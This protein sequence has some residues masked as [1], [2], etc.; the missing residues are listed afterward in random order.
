MFTRKP[1]QPAT[2]ERAA[3]LTAALL[4]TLSSMAPAIRPLAVGDYRCGE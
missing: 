3:R 2:I 1:H 4:L